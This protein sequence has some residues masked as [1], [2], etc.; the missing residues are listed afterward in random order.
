MSGLFAATVKESHREGSDGVHESG[1]YSTIG[2]GEARK[3]VVMRSPCRGR[4]P[5]PPVM[6]RSS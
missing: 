2:G 5:R 6:D 3:R 1:C 4:R